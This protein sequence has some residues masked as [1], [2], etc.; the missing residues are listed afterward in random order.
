M[1]IPQIS[2]LAL[3]YNHERW[4]NSFLKS[5]LAQTDGRW[6]LILVD[7]CSSDATIDIINSFNDPRIRVIRHKINLGI[8]AGINDAVLAAQAPICA[9][10]AADDV[11]ESDY[12]K[13][14]LDGFAT[15]RNCGVGYAR[16][17]VINEHGKRTGKL[18]EVEFVGEVSGKELFRKLFFERTSIASPGMA[19]RTEAIR[20][21]TPIP[22]G[23]CQCQDYFIEIMLAMHNSA[24]F[25]NEPVVGYRCAGQGVSQNGGRRVRLHY[26][27][28]VQLVLDDVSRMIFDDETLRKYFGDIEILP[29]DSIPNDMIEFWLGRLAMRSPEIEKREW[30][31]RKVIGKMNERDGAAIL[32]ERYD[33]GFGNCI[34]AFTGSPIPLT[35]TEQ[36]LQRYVLRVKILSALII[37]IIIGVVVRYV[38][39]F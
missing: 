25:I 2:I 32:R 37:T 18:S 8:N 24:F 13:T 10:I 1:N 34:T 30:G 20:A 28:E 16:F 31:L 35:R 15:H 39:F 33:W 5:V 9:L 27:A 6:E 12:V 36:R 19:F 4:I 38:V 17:A 11:L 14:M 22:V 23:Y 7:D 21:I 29:K 3:V 26:A